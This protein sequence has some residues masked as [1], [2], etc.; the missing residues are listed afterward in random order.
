[1]SQNSLKLAVAVVLS[2]ASSLCA[3][4]AALYHELYRPQFHFTADK[5]WLN[6][7]NGLVYYQGEYHQ[8]FQRTPD[9]INGGLKSWGHSIG[10]DLMHWRQLADAIEPDATGDVWSGSAVVDW[11][12]TAGFQTGTEKTLVAMWTSSGPF[13]QCLSYSNDKGR[14][15]TRY[16]G[17]PVIPHL[18]AQN[19]DPKLIWYEPTRQWVVALYLDRKNDYGVFTSPDLKHWTQIQTLTLPRSTEC[20]DFFPMAVNGDK[21]K[22]KW[23][24]TGAGG[25]YMVGS[26]DGKTFTGE[27]ASQTVEFGANCYAA[28]TISDMPAK[29]PRRIQI[30]WMNGGKYPQMPF[31]QQLSIPCELTLHAAADGLRVY[32]YPVREVESLRTEPNGWKETSLQGD[33]DLLAGLTGDCLDIVAQIEPDAKARVVFTIRGTPVEYDAEN[34]SLINGRHAALD[35]EGGRIKLRILVDRTS[36]EAFGNDGQV[37]I[38][39]CFV[40][41]P[42]DRSISLHC[43]TGTAR[44]ISLEIYKMK[45]IWE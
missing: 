36:I 2:F 11:N 28:Q 31:N 16:S 25:R 13:N 9:K 20:P 15:W 17:N 26:F 34:H 4:D 6:D 39:R 18:I 35:V 29:D 43:S 1:M 40:P 21:S 5:G 8:F 10:T 32:K 33:A 41:K 3:Q 12:N 24:F 27:T 44:V 23:I 22:T 38:T 45:S 14:T 19:R 7:P 42:E 30:G 37:A